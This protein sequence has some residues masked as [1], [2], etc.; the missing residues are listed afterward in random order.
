MG[1]L[2]IVPDAVPLVAGD[3]GAVRVKGSRITL[4]T[5]IGAYCQ[6]ES[7]EEIRYQFPT[8][9]L[10][11]IYAVIAYYLHHHVEVDAYLEEGRIE[12]ERIRALIEERFPPDGIRAK[13]LARRAAKTVGPGASSS[14]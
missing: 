11:D 14:S 1:S 4:D 8:L 3:D 5:V 13:L 2:T 12:A 9:S 7:P 10:A 6:G